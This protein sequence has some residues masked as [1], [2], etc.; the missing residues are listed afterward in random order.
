MSK[1]NPTTTRGE[2]ETMPIAFVGAGPGDPALITLKGHQLLQEADVVIYTGS[3]VPKDLISHLS[4]LIYNSAGITLEQVISIMVPA[5]KSG[6]RVVRLH[7]GDPA[8][9][10]AIQEQIECLRKENIPFEVVPGVTAGFAAA[11]VLGQELTIPGITQT[12]IF[13]RI[14][15]R[16]PVPPSEELSRFA[17]IHATLILY[18][19]VGHIRQVQEDLLA[20]GYSPDTPVEVIE[21]VSWPTQRVISGELENI[22]IK[23]EQAGISKTAVILV[24]KVLSEP[25]HLHGKR[26]LLYAPEF[27]HGYRK[28]LSH[29]RVDTSSEAPL[30]CY[31]SANNK[32]IPQRL[33]F[34]YLTPGGR[35]LAHRLSELF[36]NKDVLIYSYSEL[37]EDQLIKKIW[38]RDIGFVFIMASGIVIRAI[39]PLLKSK[40]DDPAVVVMDEAG[41]HAVSLLSGHLGGANELA[42]MLALKAGGQAVI[43]TASDTLGLVALDMWARVQDMVPD[44][45]STLKKASAALVASGS[46]KTY[47][48]C[49][50]HSLPAG[51]IKVYDPG[52]AWLII[53]PYLIPEVKPILHLYPRIFA[54]GIGCNRDTPSQALETAAEEFLNRHKVSP[55]TLFTL[56]SI[57]AKKDEACLLALGQKWDLDIRFFTAEQLNTVPV[58]KPSQYAMEAVG[59]Y[60]VAEPS[61]I[62][63]VDN[64][65]LR[66]QKEKTN[67][68]TL[69]LGERAFALTEDQIF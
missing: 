36:S 34:V 40:P 29:S 2:T 37:V 54:L 16:T 8:I 14:G 61:A 20:G 43:T 63:A 6:R 49:Q 17:K 57:D 45:R 69:A 5:A 22:A 41:H 21:K 15:G 31:S 39:A 56:A 59:A 23:I 47:T 3:L 32:A 46:L 19:S 65:K 64:G 48:D 67:G 25:E 51:L 4:A 30:D 10:S 7:T 12:V 62:L 27:S 33:F 24:G 38:Q 18:L 44:D 11:A 55:K 66:V 60:G 58:K 1:T 68:I 52:K 26:S 42:R 53:S 9:Y 13:S 50:V 35:T 28:G